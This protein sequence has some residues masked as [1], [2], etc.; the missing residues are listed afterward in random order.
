MWSVVLCIVFVAVSVPAAKAQEEIEPRPFPRVYNTELRNNAERVYELLNEL[1]ARHV[2]RA[3]R[4]LNRLGSLLDRLGDVAERRARQGYDVSVVR[5]TI[6]TAR[7]QLD[8]ARIALRDQSD[9]TYVLDD[10]TDQSIRDRLRAVRDV[11]YEDLTIVRVG[12][13]DAISAVR[14]VARALRIARPATSSS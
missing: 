1:N 3:E 14:D 8:T 9:R 5:E 6:A 10:A 12:V 11:M 7:E 4:I 13:R 2:E